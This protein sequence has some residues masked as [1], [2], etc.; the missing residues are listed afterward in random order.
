VL[1]SGALASI[2]GAPGIGKTYLLCAVAAAVTT[3]GSVQGTDG[4]LERLQLGNVLYLSGDDRRTQLI[5]KNRCAVTDTL[6]LPALTGNESLCKRRAAM[7][8]AFLTMNWKNSK[9]QQKRV[10]VSV[11][12]FCIVKNQ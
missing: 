5:L 11:T 1:P 4:E 6:K 8:S 2:T 9:N 12:R 7:N 3:G 10:I